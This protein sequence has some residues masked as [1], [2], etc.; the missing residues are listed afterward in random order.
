M[1][2]SIATNIENRG[3]LESLFDIT[4]TAHR[5]TQLLLNTTHTVIGTDA[6]LLIPINTRQ[7]YIA[8]LII[9][10]SLI[11][12]IIFFICVVTFKF[13]FSK[14]NVHKMNGPIYMNDENIQLTLF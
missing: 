5:F 7:I 13:C 12:I 8:M 14:K 9:I 4:A 2:S 1:N 3:I 6:N 10:F 11:L